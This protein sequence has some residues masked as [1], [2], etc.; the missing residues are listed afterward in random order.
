MLLPNAEIIARI[1]SKGILVGC[2]YSVHGQMARTLG[3]P[4]GG[5]GLFDVP[6]QMARNIAEADR[7]VGCSAGA[8]WILSERPG[9]ILLISGEL[10]TLRLNLSCEDGLGVT[11]E[12]GTTDAA[13]KS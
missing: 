12:P 13:W 8:A 7:R 10:G 3:L 9:R 1:M 2:A 4:E 6:E 11:I 5:S